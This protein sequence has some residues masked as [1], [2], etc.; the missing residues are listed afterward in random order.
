MS[1]KSTLAA[2]YLKNINV[3][4]G[5]DE[6]R[7]EERIAAC[8]HYFGHRFCCQEFLNRSLSGLQMD[9]HSF[10]PF[11]FLSHPFLPTLPTPNENFYF[12][13]ILTRNLQT[14]VLVTTLCLTGLLQQLIK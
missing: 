12:K 5:F 8:A 3:L 1:N 6:P 14:A 9:H 10:T 2:I 11:P 4:H 7:T 13:V